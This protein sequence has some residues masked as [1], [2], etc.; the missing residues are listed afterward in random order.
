MPSLR[1]APPLPATRE[2]C[3]IGLGA[4]IGAGGSM[5]KDSEKECVGGGTTAAPALTLMAPN[6]PMSLEPS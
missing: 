3:E 1:A 2:Q 5:E 4:D 6:K